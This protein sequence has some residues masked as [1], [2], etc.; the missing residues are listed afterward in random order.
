MADTS[1][2]APAPGAPRR[3]SRVLAVEE[4]RRHWDLGEWR[5][6]QR[7][8]HGRTNV[9]HFVTTDRG[10]F[11][12][13]VSNGRKTEESMAWEF[14]LLEHL[15]GRG[16]PAPR[17]VPTGE[18][19]PWA[20]VGG[21]LCSVTERIPG[22]FPD[23][24]NPVHRHEMM[25]A[26]AWFHRE[27]RDLPEGARPPAR[28]RVPI[29][30]AGAGLLAEVE[31]LV[32]ELV[33][34]PDLVRFRR[35]REALEPAFRASAA[36]AG[37]AVLPDMITHG[38][39]GYTAVLFEGDR[40][41]GVLDFER[42]ARELRALDLAYT[43]RA[44]ARSPGARGVPESGATEGSWD[45]IRLSELVAAYGALEPLTTAEVDRFPMVLRAQRLIKVAN[46]A[47]NLLAKHAAVT[48]G[49]K[50]GLKFIEMLELEA[51]RVGWIEAHEMELTAAVAAGAR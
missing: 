36:L 31:M 4:I 45:T 44:L 47:A 12:V 32:A 16:Y 3:P 8:P 6:W 39:F 34:A 41:T 17:I 42:A 7:T 50:D 27:A 15:V 24:G 19:R 51:A 40:L 28:S 48:Q 25:R 29:L 9:S 10:R 35:S 5:E 30:P 18:G 33:S 22:D 37:G 14:A 46:K 23:T 26:L 2:P 43:L 38:S 21:S 20:W 13:R 11:V 1:T 49:E